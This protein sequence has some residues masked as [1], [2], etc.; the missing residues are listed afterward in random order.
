MADNC[1]KGASLFDS[2]P[3]CEDL[4]DECREPNPPAFY[5]SCTFQLCDGEKSLFQCWADEHVSIAG[6]KVKFFHLDIEESSRDPL[7]DESIERVFVGSYIFKA[8]ITYPESTPE[9]R[10]EGL[11]A[12]WDAEMWVPSSQIIQ[13]G[14]PV[15]GE[16]DVIQF[17]DDS[18]EWYKKYG[19]LEQDIPGS[20]YL[21]DV[22]KV[23]EDGHL[24]DQAAFVGFK[25]SLK[26][27]TEFT[28][29]R[30][31]AND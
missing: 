8:F 28:A 30:R 22:I 10:E 24:F 26:R 17:W 4:T 13:S 15:P 2:L 19:V 25:C 27:R 11:H 5:E 23:D 1:S 3:S 9:A 16:G 7:Y 31:M 12:T 21:F 18:V 14:A 29:E 6:T 20:G